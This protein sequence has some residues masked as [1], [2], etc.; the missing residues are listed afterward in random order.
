MNRVRKRI[1][2]L[3]AAALALGVA[4]CGDNVPQRLAD[5]GA[6]LEG[7]VKYGADQL[8][9]A[10]VTVSGDGGT[11]TGS[12]GEDG[13]YKIENVPVGEVKVA[14]N[15]QAAMGQYQTAVMQAGAYKGPEGKGGRQKVDVKM[16]QVP[17][18]FAD[19]NKSGLKTTVNKGANTYNIDI[20]KG[21]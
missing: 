9:F 10:Q 19:P 11:V 18:K 20:P 17:D 12:V 2:A 14:V 4:S 5:S 15:T 16:V 6:T 3:V 1:V 8:Q 7:T 13:K 21:K